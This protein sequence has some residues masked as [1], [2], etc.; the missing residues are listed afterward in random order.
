MT[1]AKD[2]AV[3]KTRHCKLELVL[4]LQVVIAVAYL[5]WLFVV[6]NDELFESEEST[7]SVPEIITSNTFQ[8]KQHYKHKHFIRIC[9]IEKNFIRRN[10]DNGKVYQY[11]SYNV[12][13]KPGDRV[14][15]FQSC[16]FL[17]VCQMIMRWQNMLILSIYQVSFLINVNVH[18]VDKQRK[19][20]PWV[21]MNLH[22]GFF[23]PNS[24][25]EHQIHLNL[26]VLKILNT[27]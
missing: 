3:L 20:S 21:L 16:S 14:L 27:E 18:D 10:Y 11:T 7:T 2:L 5:L 1:S 15:Q 23:C 9:F 19:E 12:Q 22:P 24:I 6:D 8:H 25:F 26:T 17:Q 4:Q 13:T